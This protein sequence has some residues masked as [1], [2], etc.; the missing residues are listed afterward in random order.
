[1]NVKYMIFDVDGTLT[2]GK[3]YI[4]KNGEVFKAFNVKDGCAIHD[5]LPQLEIV[6]VVI[7]ARK[8]DIVENRCEELNICECYQ[9]VCNKKQ[10]LLELIQKWEIQPDRNGIYNQVA[11]IGDDIIDLGC[12][13]ICGFTACPQDAVEEVKAKV[14]YVSKYN[15]GD[16]AVRDIIEW[17]KCNKNG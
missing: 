9:S 1:M 12:M 13:E 3:L 17:Y 6:P 10:K 16:G 7:T 5:I 4:G 11:Y 2:D 14:D 8:S 15:A